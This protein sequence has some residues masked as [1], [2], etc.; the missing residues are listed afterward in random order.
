MALRP[1]IVRYLHDC[2]REDNSRSILWNLLGSSSEH[3]IFLRGK[4]ELLDGFLDETPL[5]IREAHPAAEAATTYQK[6]K[7]LLYTAFHIVGK[8]ALPD[9]KPRSVCAPLLTFPGSI[10]IDG[11][12]AALTIERDGRRINSGVLD[13]LQSEAGDIPLNDLIESVL[14]D[15]Q[16]NEAE[17]SAAAR[18]LSDGISNLDASTIW[19]FP[20]LTDGKTIRDAAKS[21]TPSSGLT[22]FPSAAVCLVKRPIESRGVL[23]ELEDLAQ[24]DDHSRP[25]QVLVGG[26]VPPTATP[27]TTPHSVPAVLSHSQ[28]E[29]LHRARTEALSL[30]IGPPGTGKSY[31]IAAIALDHL[32][33]GD[34]VLIASKMNHA[35]DVIASKIEAQ[36][37]A[38]GKVVRAGRRHYL[39]ELKQYVD[40]LLNRPASPPGEIESCL[41]SLERSFR[42]STAELGRLEKEISRS[43]QRHLS[44]G[45]TLSALAGGS[46]NWLK[47]LS[48]YIIRKRN[49]SQ[50]PLWKLMADL[51]EKL[52]QR[53]F[54][55]AEL[56]KQTQNLRLEQGLAKN[57]PAIKG[58]RS[59]LGARTGTRQEALF[60][61]IDLGVLLDILPVWLTNLSDAHRVLPYR[62]ELFDIAIIDEASQCDIASCLPVL[63]RA[64]RAVIVGDPNQLRHLSFLATDRQ[65]EFAATHELTS[66]ES[67][68]FDYRNHSILD[69]ASERT[70]SQSGVHF[71]NE[72]FRSEPAIIRFS[73]QHFYSE[74]L[75]VM[76]EKPG[77]LARPSICHLQVDGKRDPAGS[78]PTEA[79]AIIAAI[80]AQLNQSPPDVDRP[81]PSIGVLSPFRS[82]V[83]HLATRINEH[84]GNEIFARHQLMVG[85]AHTFQGEER[86]LMFLSFAIDLHSPAAS[87]RFLER[88]DVFNVAITRARQHQTVISSISPESLPPDSLLRQYLS[89]IDPASEPVAPQHHEELA[90][91]DQFAREVR[92]ALESRGFQT[93]LGC[94]VAGLK[95]DLLAAK[96]GES[97]AIDLVG[98]PGPS[99]HVFPLE[100]YKMFRRADLT[101]WPLPY[102][103]WL[104][105]RD[106]CLE[107]IEAALAP[108]K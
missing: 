106:S 105:D 103:N 83:D 101:L 38:S 52:G 56:L 88:P 53:N 71:L 51:H 98:C 6:E 30:V 102:A 68:L 24:G 97:L 32:H 39:R 58:L 54:L 50:P 100:R 33:R 23:T 2:Y 65:R 57:R 61:S 72:H 13:A 27:S 45:E 34:S 18:I 94:P 92:A 40:S 81:A 11:D 62:Q 10:R 46:R 89:S 66:T 78:N 26:A 49:R 75:N 43:S 35:V 59:A 67:E 108:A 95:I 8:L 19:Q 3:Q 74:R 21:A 73:N 84:F 79:D 69:L 93:W 22:L 25:L 12:Y 63:Q 64:R 1:P 47:R 41:S 48:G 55:S 29:I 14:D 31:T 4:E 28:T 42:K 7:Q 107:A 16:I 44:W 82:Q 99:A 104:H 37:G 91:L 60:A 80:E 20:A 90:R 70:D 15:W 36:L 77:K 87:R 85:T 76:T 9:G 5:P 86:D 96:G 17:V